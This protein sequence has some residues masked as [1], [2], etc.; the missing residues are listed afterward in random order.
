MGALSKI[1][2]AGFDVSLVDGFIQISPA[3]KLTTIQREF[4]KQHRAEIIHELKADVLTLSATHGAK[5]IDWLASIGEKDQ[6]IIDYTIDRCKVDPE[7]LSYF[8]KRAYGI[9]K[10][11]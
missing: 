4:L 11:H 3:D 1:R 7:T 8:L 5:I 10:P 2:T 6:L 9:A